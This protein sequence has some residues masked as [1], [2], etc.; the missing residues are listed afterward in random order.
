MQRLSTHEGEPGNHS[1]TR[2][3][4]AVRGV[5]KGLRLVMTDRVVRE[6]I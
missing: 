1:T 6:V 2:G 5:W 3:G 4:R